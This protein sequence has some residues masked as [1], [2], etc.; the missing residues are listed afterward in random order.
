MALWVILILSLK[1]LKKALY[2]SNDFP[3]LRVI[4]FEHFFIEYDL[5][6]LV[7]DFSYNLAASHLDNKIT[8]LVI[9]DVTL[10]FPSL[11]PPIHEPNSIGLK[12]L[13][14]PLPIFL[15]KIEFNL[16]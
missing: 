3:T 12:F 16:L 10:G 5:I 4:C 6:I 9:F 15:R 2:G 1:G 8:S 7:R 14:S 11:S 13:G